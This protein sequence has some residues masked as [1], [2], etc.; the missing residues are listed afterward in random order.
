[1]SAITTQAAGNWSATGTWTGGVVPGNG[2][3]VILNHAVT[4]DVNTTVGSSP[5][6]GGTAAIFCNAALT[7]A[8]GIVLTC[9]GDLK[10][11]NVPF[12]MGAGST[13]K[14][15]ASLAG[16]PSTARYVCQIG[17]NATDPSA[18][19]VVNGTSGSRCSIQS[20]N[21]NGAA[22]GRFTNNGND[23]SGQVDATYFDLLRIGDASNDAFAYWLGSGKIFSLQNYTADACGSL[24]ANN[25]G[26]YDTAA[27][28]RHKNG[29]TRNSVGST[30]M[31]SGT[32]AGAITGGGV[33]ECIDCEFDGQ[34]LFYNCTGWTITGT[35][36]R[37]IYFT[38]GGPWAQFYGNMLV[39]PTSDT[40]DWATEGAM[41]D[42]YVIRPGDLVN[43]HFVT[44]GDNTTDLTGNIFDMPDGVTNG[45]GDCITFNS[46]SVLKTINVKNNLVLQTESGINVG[47]MLSCLGGAN[48]T[49][50]A[51]H[52]T[53]CGDQGIYLGETYA[54]HVD[55]LSSCKSN[56]SF[57][58]T[59]ATAWIISADPGVVLDVV[60]SA[61]VVKNG[62]W[63]PKGTTGYQSNL[64]FSSG[65]PGS[66]D[67]NGDPGF[68]DIN[69][70]IKKWDLSL[71][72]P[73]TVAHALAELGKRNDAAGYNSAYTIAA[74][75]AYVLAG[76]APTN[77]AFQAAHDGVNGGWMG[78]VSG[79]VPSPFPPLGYIT[80]NLVRF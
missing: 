41:T 21:T 59:A 29:T 7:L 23:N 33:R 14:F 20:V 55:M 18:K 68:V 38:T 2:D 31:V 25:G 56:L 19:L 66:G 77:I 74:L 46:P 24:G 34:V 12:T 11:N 43:P 47:T 76:F 75:R 22:N 48:L 70:N 72:G 44:T 62:V 52:N 28:V 17:T 80:P 27:I 39:I 30:S 8:A 36:F 13:F 16:T 15:D 61:N 26:A 54:G 73:G 51:E 37:T 78:A 35:T 40:G 45:A 71:G 42:C 57:S 67:V 49:V 4:V 65:N 9:R 60:H 32:A 3:T 64:S 5:A 79:S 6:A 50:V 1:M 53:Y 58:Q 63:N 69:R 10:L